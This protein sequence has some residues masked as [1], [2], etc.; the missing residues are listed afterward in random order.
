MQESTARQFVA[1]VK[2]HGGVT[3]SVHHE[4]LPTSGFFVSD[5]GGEV[6]PLEK[7]TED[8]VRDF[9]NVHTFELAHAGVYLGGWLSDGQ[10]Y[11]DITRHYVNRV[12]AL[13]AAAVNQQLAIWDVANAEEIAA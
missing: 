10:V 5:Q 2:D 3:V 8:T 4:S 9:A 7:F 13:N 6:V 12:S 1:S 11:L